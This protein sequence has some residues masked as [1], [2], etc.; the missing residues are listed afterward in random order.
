[1][2]PQGSILWHYLSADE[3]ALVDD[4]AFLV[5]D[6]ARHADQEPTDYSYLVFPFAKLYEGFLKDLFLDLGIISQREYYSN[7]YRIGKA[8][9]PNLVRRLGPRSAYG[10]LTKRFGDELA[11][12][13]WHAWK[14]GR[15]LVFHYY[16]H[17]LKALTRTGA[18]ELV[19]MIVGAMEEAV[20]KTG[21]RPKERG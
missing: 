9:S 13:L 20:R 7:H 10:Q 2:I 17:N 6:S 14:E 15:N 11:A 18:M 19:T 3:R 1:M 4:G 8:L 12:S 5:S 21:V 16:P